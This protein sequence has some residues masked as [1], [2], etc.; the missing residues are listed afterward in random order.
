[1]ISFVRRFRHIATGALLATFVSLPVVAEDSEIYVNLGTTKE[2]QPNVLFVIDTSGSMRTDVPVTGGPDR[3]DIVR[4]AALTLA[5]NLR[6]VNL[7]LMRYD[8]G[9]DGGFVLQPVADLEVPTH[10]QAIIDTLT[11]L[12]DTTVNGVRVIDGNTPLSETYYEAFLYF[13]GGKVD[14]GTNSISTSR[15]QD[16]QST[17]ISPISHQCQKNYIVY[18]TDG[19]PTSD[20]G[21]NEATRIPRVVAGANCPAGDDDE[22]DGACMDEL[23]AYMSPL[24]QDLIGTVEGDQSI[25]TYMIGFG[26]DVQPNG[27]FSLDEVAEA[28]GTE[29]AF[30]AT[31][32]ATLSTALGAIFDNLTSDRATFVTP[33]ISVDSFNRAQASS[34]LYFSLFKASG[35]FHWDGNLKKYAIRNGQI[36]DKDG[37]AAVTNGFFDTNATSFWSAVAD[38]DEVEQGG[39]VALLREPNTTVAG[40]KIYTSLVSANLSDPTNWLTIDENDNDGPNGPFTDALVGTGTDT[41]GCSAACREAVLWARG[42]DVNTAA[43]NDFVRK[44][45]DPLHGQPG[46]VTY[47]FYDPVKTPVPDPP[48][49]YVFMP[50][51]DGMLHAF[52]GRDGRELW[53]FMPTEMLG[54][55]GALRRNAASA[56]RSLDEFDDEAV[57]A[58]GLDGDVRVLRLDKNLNGKIEVTNSARTSDR[59]WLFFGMRSGGNRYYGVDVTQP[60]SPVLLWSIGPDELPGVGLTWS[61]PVVTRVS[62]TGDNANDDDEKFVLIFGGGYDYGQETQTYSADDTGNRVFM[63]D[64]SSGK[65]LWFAGG[66]FDP[67]TPPDVP[68]DLPLVAAGNSMDNAIP[69]RVTVLDQNGDTFADRMYVGDMGGRIWRFDIINNSDAGDLVRGGIFAELGNAGSGSP[70]DADNRRFYNAPDISLV[71]KRGEAP[72]YNVAIGSGYRGHPLD[73]TTTERFYSLRDSKPF[74][75]FSQDDY[76]ARTNGVILDTDTDLVEVSTNPAGSTVTTASKGW[77]YTL[78]RNG[79]GEKVLAEATTVDGVVLFPT[80]EPVAPG[81]Q[82]PCAPGSI[83][84]VYALTAFAGKPAINFQDEQQNND[85]NDIGNEDVFTE[86]GQQGIAGAVNVA[87]LRPNGDDDGNGDGDGEAPRTICLAGVEVLSRCIDVGGTVRTYWQRS[88]AP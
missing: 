52:D 63:V 31:D 51:N 57:P 84:R 3:I 71:Q 66:G 7:G 37:D 61:P 33:S 1:M 5:R 6:N 2:A 4:E 39:A 23:A 85:D 26:P 45:G 10:R 14:Y 54:R 34:D 77:K 65:R 46:V 79:D 42:Y 40:R 70:S 16:D 64:A 58:F 81:I 9:A 17:Y 67:D 59:V 21:A 22:N 15:L 41:G 18:L 83:N 24:D 73:G 86:L 44:L 48:D 62:V 27:N 47:G 78:N 8:Q 35:R 76:D 43:A 38:G 88:D 55:L 36:V 20:V 75:V 80:Y 69:S 11:G 32:S 12:R 28:G 87:L 74:A 56:A 25:Q 50:T 68:P 29:S 60:D 30:V 53:A 13:T 49:T 19:L 82:D 72:F